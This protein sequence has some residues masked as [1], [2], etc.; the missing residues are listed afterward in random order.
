M[1]AQ[2]RTKRTTT[3]G[4]AAHRATI[5]QDFNEVGDAAK[6]VATDSVE[7]VRD[8]ANQYLEQGRSRAKSIGESMQSKVQEQPVKSLLIASAVGFLLGAFWIRR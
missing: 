7:A 2:S 4:L 1:A 8:T 6:R 5:A 3:N